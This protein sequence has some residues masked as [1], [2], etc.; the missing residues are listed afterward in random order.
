MLVPAPGDFASARRLQTLPDAASSPASRGDNGHYLLNAP[1]GAQPLWL[2]DVRPG[3]PIAALIPLDGSVL[4]RVAGLLRLQHHLDGRPLGP[5]PSAL[6]ITTRLRQRLTAMVRA[7]DGH[8]AGASYR[9][10][11]VVLYGRDAVSKY[12][13]KTS[14]VRG[15]TI[16]LVRDAV[17]T[18]EGGYRQLLRAKR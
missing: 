16:R 18:M 2:R 4:L 14:S 13:W 1:P 9:Q 15:Q 3:T 8:M 5:L 11:A 17:A 10:I 12:A 6:T 7:L